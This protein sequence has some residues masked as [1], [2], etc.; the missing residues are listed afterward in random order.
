[1][2]FF[3]IYLVLMECSAGLT[4]QYSDSKNYI[5]E[6]SELCLQCLKRITRRITNLVRHFRRVG[7]FFLRALPIASHDRVIYDKNLSVQ[8]YLR[9]LSLLTAEWF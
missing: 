7:G 3:Y 1:M 6:L 8:S 4:I 5:T 2:L 9:P